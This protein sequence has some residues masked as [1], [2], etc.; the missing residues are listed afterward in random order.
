MAADESADERPMV[1]EWYK[2]VEGNRFEV[3]AVDEEEET[4][5]VQHFGGEVEEFSFDSWDEMPLVVIPAPEDWSGPFDDLEKDDFGDT[6]K[7]LHPEGWS[8]PWD[9]LDRE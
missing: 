7:V 5:E 1:G 3:V 9:E 4:I 8:G 2:S 6:E